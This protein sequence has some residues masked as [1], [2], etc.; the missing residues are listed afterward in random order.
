MHILGTKDCQ[1]VAVKLWNGKTYLFTCPVALGAFFL[2]KRRVF[3]L[4]IRLLL[5]IL[6]VAC[7]H[8]PRI[9]LLL[10]AAICVLLDVLSELSRILSFVR[11]QMGAARKG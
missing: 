6:E 8:R 10:H 1:I 11:Q 5:S 9:F 4:V 7:V 2:A 3:R